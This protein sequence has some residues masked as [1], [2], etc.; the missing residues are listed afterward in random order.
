[1]DADADR[2]W[3]L[4]AYRLPREPS[5]PRIAVWR[6]LDQLGVVRLG[7]G[8]VGVPA[9]ARTS[10]QVDWIAEEIRQAGGTASAWLAT[11]TDR[12]QE[13]ALVEDARAA[14]TAEYRTVIAAAEMVATGTDTERGR[15][16]RRLRTQLRR[17]NR[18]DFF[19]APLRDEARA[20][21]DS[22]AGD[23]QDNTETAKSASA[24][25]TP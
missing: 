21:V 7:D 23:G 4:L 13:Q 20:A 17:I 19:A 22:L 9:D 8:L 12:A 14:R 2:R 10:E 11:P 6:K 15:A 16:L 5:T 3:V 1:M 24:G 18:R 25:G